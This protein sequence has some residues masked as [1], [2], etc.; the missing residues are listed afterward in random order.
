MTIAAANPV[1][2]QRFAQ[3]APLFGHWDRLHD[4]IRSLWPTKT[5]AHLA[6]AAGVSQRAAELSLAERRQFAPD[7]LVALLKGEH[8]GAVLLAL[9]EG[10]DA[11]WR[12][13]FRE[14]YA[15]KQLEAQIAELQSRLAALN[16]K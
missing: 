10:S 2:E 6:H 15:R 9:T 12:R 3:S 5:S 1:N 16:G 11:A 14:M 4:L 8:G 13:E 7:T